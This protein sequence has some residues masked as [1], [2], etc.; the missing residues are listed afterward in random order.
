MTLE[1]KYCGNGKAVYEEALTKMLRK[2][3]DRAQ[4]TTLSPNYPRTTEDR[5]E[6]CLA[7][8]VKDLVKGYKGNRNWTYRNQR[9]SSEVVLTKDCV[10]DTRARDMRRR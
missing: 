5:A 4:L 9:F 3:S 7:K 10:M 6:P 2:R 8:L 1:I